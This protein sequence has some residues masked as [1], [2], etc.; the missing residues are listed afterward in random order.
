MR[1]TEEAEQLQTSPGAVAARLD[2]AGRA[3]GSPAL[4]LACCFPSAQLE[5]PKMGA[6]GTWLTCAGQR[7]EDEWAF[8]VASPLSLELLWELEGHACLL[9]ALCLTRKSFPWH[10]QLRINFSSSLCNWQEP[11]WKLIRIHSLFLIMLLLL[12]SFYFQH[13]LET[14][15]I[16]CK[17]NEEQLSPNILLLRLPGW[18]VWVKSHIQ[19]IFVSTAQNRMAWGLDIHQEI[20]TEN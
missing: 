6:N 16:S 13:S 7:Q 5:L 3:G 19:I 10:R 1:E 9:P 17:K 11:M 18:S 15:A 2:H 4:P 14:G 8:N 12:H 20:H